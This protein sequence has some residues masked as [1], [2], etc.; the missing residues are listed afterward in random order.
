MVLYQ[1]RH[2]RFTRNPAGLAKPSLPLVTSRH[3]FVLPAL[4]VYLISSTS[5]VALLPVPL[6]W[7]DNV[8][9]IPDFG[10][11]K[12]SIG[13]TQ[14]V[15]EKSID[16]LDIDAMTADCLFGLTR[17]RGQYPAQLS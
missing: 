15:Q 8:L 1:A 10:L 3:L 13:A 17:H 11:F 16:L 4:L 6:A 7:T 14:P 2:H 12:L 9:L 5:F